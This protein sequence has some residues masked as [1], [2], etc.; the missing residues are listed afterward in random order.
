MFAERFDEAGL[1]FTTLEG[2]PI[3]PRNFVRR[4]FDKT[5]EKAGLPHVTFHSLRHSFASL[6]IESGE[7]PRVIQELMGHADMKT[8]MSIYSH[9][10]LGLKERAMQRLEEMLPTIA[11]SDSGCCTVAVNL[12]EQ[13]EQRTEKQAL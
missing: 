2:N 13:D 3:D 1:V 9:V 7:H 5:L 8:A 4:F 10:S 12:S 11:D 6:L